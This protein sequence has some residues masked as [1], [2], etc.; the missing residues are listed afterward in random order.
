MRLSLNDVATTSEIGEHLERLT[1]AV[2]RMNERLSDLE[3]AV[4]KDEPPT[5]PR[6]ST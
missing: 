6:P 1:E 2:E 3:I 4:T 5:R